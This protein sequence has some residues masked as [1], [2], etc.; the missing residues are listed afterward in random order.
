MQ[1]EKRYWI[2]ETIYIYFFIFLCSAALLIC[3][4]MLDSSL[5]SALIVHMIQSVTTKDRGRTKE[6][7]LCQ[8]ILQELLPLDEK[9]DADL[10]KLQDKIPSTWHLNVFKVCCV[11]CFNFGFDCFSCSLK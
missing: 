8:R 11:L 7:Q 6:C 2:L 5:P 10:G 9:F 3:N 1:Y 4:N